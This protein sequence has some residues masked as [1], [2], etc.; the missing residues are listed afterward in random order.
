MT[1]Q[2]GI[3][4]QMVNRLQ[5]QYITSNSLQ[6]LLLAPAVSHLSCVLSAAELDIYLLYSFVLGHASHMSY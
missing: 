4:M 2:W 5:L 6:N 3:S 1:A